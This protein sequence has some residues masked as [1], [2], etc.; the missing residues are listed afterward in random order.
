MNAAAWRPALTPRTVI[1]FA[2]A[3]LF[4]HISSGAGHTPYDNYIRL[5]DAWLHGRLWIVDPGPGI[6]AINYAGH[7]YIIEPPLPALLALPAVLVWGADANQSLLCVACAALAVAAADV[8]LGRLALPQTARNWLLYFFAAG[9][10]LWW[11]AAFGAVWMYAHVVAVM[12]ATCALAEW[13]G[14][15]RAWLLGLLIGCAALSRFPVIL[16]VP[17]FLY[18]LAKQTAPPQRGR[19]LLLFGAGLAPLLLLLAAYDQARWGTPLDVGYTLWYHRDEVGE[20]TGS[21]FR[22]AYLPFNLYSFFML[23]PS[24]YK[25]FPW[26]RPSSYGV[27]LVLT[28]PALFLAL[29]APWRSAQTRALW[30]AVAL[31]ALPSLLYYVNGYE[32]FGMRHSLDFLPFMLPLAARGFV[33]TPAGLGL[34]LVAY[35]FA[36][37]AYGMWYSWTYHAYTVVPR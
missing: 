7:Y 11:C 35:S 36:A 26:L 28:S 24:F 34:P 29:A 4:Y 6:D 9:T 1:V 16:C 22:L 20:P 3:F 13:Y 30:A 32:Q 18:W 17:P 25:A 10:V 5:A 37:N 15:R 23:A 12:F 21:P 8:L 31:V 19:Q 2:L 27:S 14:Q 33:R